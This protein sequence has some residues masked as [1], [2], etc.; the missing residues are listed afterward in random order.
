MSSNDTPLP[1]TREDRSAFFEELTREDRE[2]EQM[3]A[4][5][6]RKMAREANRSRV[7]SRVFVGLAVA[8]VVAAL[9]Q[10]WRGEDS[11]LPQILTGRNTTTTQGGS[12]PVNKPFYVGEKGEVKFPVT[13][14]PWESTVRGDPNLKK[15]DEGAAIRASYAGTELVSAANV[16]PS[17]AA[18]YTSDPDKAAKDGLPNPYYSYVTS[19]DYQET[20]LSYITRLINPVYGDWQE[21]Q[22]GAKG[23]AVDRF[24]DMFTPAF[25]ASVKGK[26]PSTWLP[27]CADWQGNSYGNANLLKNGPRWVG[28][29]SNST[30]TFTWDEASSA[31]KANLVINVTYSAWQKDQ[32]VTT[33]KGVLTLDVVTNTASAKDPAHRFLIEKASLAMS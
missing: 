32:T 19:E 17:R 2:K 9:W 26:D 7:R 30:S 29:V 28:K 18:G 3:A 5:R 27:I 14:A 8:A 13:L 23:V 25:L 24:G 12:Q 22:D 15:E 4:E 21:Y 11:G 20:V 31:Y 33:K 1:G 10:P 16:L 6:I